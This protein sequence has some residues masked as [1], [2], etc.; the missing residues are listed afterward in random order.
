MVVRAKHRRRDEWRWATVGVPGAGVLE[1]FGLAGEPVALAGGQGNSVRV[2]DA[3]LKPAEGDPEATAWLAET[4]A[5]L[6][7]AG[8]RVARP[9][10]S[11]DGS[12]S[13]GGWTAARHI[14]GATPDVTAAPRWFD[15]ME[16][17]RA[18]HRTLAGLPRP[19]L[20][21]RRTDPWAIGDRVA[22]QERRPDLL[23]ALRPPYEELTACLGPLPPDPPQLIH[24]D[25]T[26]NVLFAPGLP[27]AVI[28]FSPYWRPA[29]FGEAVIVADAVIW[30]GAGS[31][32]LRAAARVRGADFLRYVA[33]AV[34][35]RLVTSS[36][37]IRAAAPAAGSADTAEA[38]AEA[39][40]FERAA[41]LV[42]DAT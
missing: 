7:E 32:L 27:P 3:V 38:L 22:W 24:G 13:H 19:D 16:A 35:Y 17:G 14:P 33:R 2:G 26:G 11:A 5:A 28:D 15:I 34:V 39:R 31:D 30:H 9:L 21:D 6:P 37:V 4:M 12:W 29:A 18:F 20:L 8:F 41:R 40:R 10:R 23:P 36:E 25:L 42:A 1:A